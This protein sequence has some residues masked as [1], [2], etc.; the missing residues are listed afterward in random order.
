[1]RRFLAPGFAV[2]IV[3]GSLALAGP[4]AASCVEAGPL[5]ERLADAHT[6]F[7]GTVVS[8]DNDGRKA[9]FEVEE[10]WKGN[11]GATA[12]VNGGPTDAEIAEARTQGL[13]I[14]TSVDRFYEVGTRYLVVPYEV[15]EVMRDNNCSATQV[16]TADLDQY[17]PETV[18]TPLTTTDGTNNDGWFDGS[19]ALS[20]AAAA[21][22]LVASAAAVVG[23]RRYRPGRPAGAA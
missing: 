14:F 5:A 12:V 2:L 11:A 23:W 6:V 9:T 8:V 3:V 13:D 15:G 10:V 4:A 19:V 16:F 22:L 18:M 17:R 7:V 1:M 21:L 20:I